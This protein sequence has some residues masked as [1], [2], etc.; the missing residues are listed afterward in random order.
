MGVICEKSPGRQITELFDAFDDDT[1]WLEKS[2]RLLDPLHPD[3]A[4][5]FRELAVLYLELVPMTFGA[6]IWTEAEAGAE[7]SPVSP[8]GGREPLLAA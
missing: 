5:R 6:W 8:P 7:A 3:L 2:A 4:K 1:E